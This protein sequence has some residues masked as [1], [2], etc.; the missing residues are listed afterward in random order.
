MNLI[1]VVEIIMA[2]IFISVMIWYEQNYCAWEE[3]Q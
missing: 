2:L 1:M 3:T